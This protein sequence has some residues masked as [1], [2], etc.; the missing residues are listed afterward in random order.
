MKVLNATHILFFKF[1]STLDRV[2]AQGAIGEL[3]RVHR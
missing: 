3:D 1:C 2:K